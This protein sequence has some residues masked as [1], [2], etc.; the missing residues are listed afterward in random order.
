MGPSNALEQ[1]R[2]V[3]P[4]RVAR[5]IKRMSDICL[6]CDAPL[7]E[8]LTG[9]KPVLHEPLTAAFHRA[10]IHPMLKFL[11][12]AI[13]ALGFMIEL[14]PDM[15]KPAI[16]HA[17]EKVWALA[18]AQSIDR[19]FR[20]GV[21]VENIVAVDALRGHLEGARAIAQ[22]GSRS[23]PHAHRAFSRI[24]IVLAN[25]Q[26]RQLLDGGE[27]QRLIKGAFVHRS[28]AE[29]CHCDAIALVH[30][31]RE[32]SANSRGNRLAENSAGRDEALVD[33]RQ[34]D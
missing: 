33:S 10:K 24:K 32:R 14:R 17:F 16:R 4:R 26:H 21:N 1:G 3:G 25:E 12:V 7:I 34:V 6:C 15:F 19:I 30:M 2:D 18:G 8:R 20:R 31:K 5:T 28:F 22:I 9:R 27:I 29:K 23:L 11:A 13:R